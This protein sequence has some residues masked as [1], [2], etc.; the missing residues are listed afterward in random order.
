MSGSPGIG[1]KKPNK[2]II[3]PADL[4]A[5][6]ILLCV[7]SDRLA[8]I[9]TAKTKSK[10]THAAICYSPT[11]VAH[12][13]DKVEKVPT[14]DFIKDFK[15]VAVFRGPDFWTEQSLSTLQVFIDGKVGT[16]TS[17]D[18]EAARSLMK[19]QKAHQIESLG[20]LREHF[21]DGVP[22]PEHDKVKYVCS[23]FVTAC[24][25][26]VGIW[27]AGMKTGYQPDALHP[28]N[29]GHDASFG[30]LVGFLQADPA[31]IIPEDDEFARSMTNGMTYGEWVEVSMDLADNPP[32][33]DQVLS[34]QEIQSLLQNLSDNTDANP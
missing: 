7:G 11:E 28:G 10:Y 1:P 9:V 31:V 8:S 19:R 18:E 3:E 32:Q 26:E 34:E 25:A 29:Q 33:T 14:S 17:Y 24:L 22:E 16:E 30:F 2:L 15:Y 5:G 4:E 6:D 27:G 20:K 12:I 13:G 21:E 23:E